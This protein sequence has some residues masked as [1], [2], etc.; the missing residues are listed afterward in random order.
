MDK[1]QAMRERVRKRVAEPLT[2]NR[3][4][5]EAVARLRGEI[6]TLRARRH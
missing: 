6:S 5:R 3:L 1:M 2:E 4:L